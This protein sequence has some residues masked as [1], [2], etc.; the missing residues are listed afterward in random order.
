MQVWR[1]YLDIFYTLFFEK[2]MK[3]NR[4]SWEKKMNEKL[5]IIREKEREKKSL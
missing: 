3:K 1:A 2:K 5:K 4:K